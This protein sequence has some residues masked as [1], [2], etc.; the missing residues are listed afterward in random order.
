M[1]HEHFSLFG[2]LL[3]EPVEGVLTS[4]G[5]PESVGHFA[6]HALSDFLEIAVLLF[7]VVTLVSYLQTYIPYE[8]MHSRL[9]RL[10]GAPGFAL[11]IGLG[12][13]S[14]FCSCSVIPILMGFLESRS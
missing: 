11:A 3:E 6:A 1:E 12:M 4:L 9:M 7:V 8:K 2:G 5:A 10:H 13:L 14:P